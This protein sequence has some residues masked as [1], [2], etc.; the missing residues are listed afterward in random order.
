[1][2]AAR[3]LGG[4]Q[5]DIEQQVLA[6]FGDPNQ[7]ARC[8]AWVYRHER[9]RLKLLTFAL[10]TVL[11]ASGLSAAVL[12]MQAGL[13]F[14]FGIPIMRVLASRHTVFE[15]LD[16]V[17]SVAAYLGIIA[18]EHQ[19]QSHRFQKAALLLAL[20]QTLLILPCAVMGWR[21]GFA[22]YGLVNG[23][24]F[25]AIQLYVTPK[26]ARVAIVALCFSLA[27]LVSALQSP[28]SHIALAA[29]SASWLAMGVGYQLMT[30][31]AARIDT[32][33]LNSLQR[34]QAGY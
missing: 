34:I 32:A 1:M 14:G 29:T 7:I 6:R 22:L 21:I 4:N 30:D 25:R 20:I 17:A 3:E 10:S 2:A 13:A 27:G 15:A 31:L 18:L 5:E 26:R 12:V 28:A 11:I 16:I 19:F 8:F 24:F 33:L 9:R 23:V